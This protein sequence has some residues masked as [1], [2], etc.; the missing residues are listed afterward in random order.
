[1]TSDSHFN[2]THKEGYQLST[3]EQI[4]CTV[5]YLKDNVVIKTSV[6]IR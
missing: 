5:V 6:Q 1:M 4:D 3:R 2:P